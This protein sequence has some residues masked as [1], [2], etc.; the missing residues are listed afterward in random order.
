MGL[1]RG[2]TAESQVR[3][4]PDKVHK[5]TQRSPEHEPGAA[6]DSLY[7]NIDFGRG[8]FG[9]DAISEKTAKEKAE[10]TKALIYDQVC[11]FIK[12]Q[13]YERKPG[14]GS[15][16]SITEMWQSGEKKIRL[17]LSN[18]NLH[19]NI[20]YA[21][22]EEVSDILN[23][24]ALIKGKYEK[25]KFTPDRVKEKLTSDKVH[26][27]CVA[28]KFS[29]EALLADNI[30]ALKN[31]LKHKSA[32]VRRAA[33][34]ALGKIHSE[35]NQD[36]ILPMI[37][38]AD[39]HVSWVAAFEIAKYRNKKASTVM[40]E[41]L[42][43][44]KKPKIKGLPSERR[45]VLASAMLKIWPDKEMSKLLETG[46]ESQN[47]TVLSL[48][49]INSGRLQKYEDVTAFLEHKEPGIR[50]TAI[51][52]LCR[53]IDP[54]N[55]LEEVLE[56]TSHLTPYKEKLLSD[57]DLNIKRLAGKLF[58]AASREIEKVD[59][60]RMERVKEA[61]EAQ[62][63]GDAF[64]APVEFRTV[65]QIKEEYGDQEFETFKKNN[66]R[67]VVPGQP[68]DDTEEVMLLTRSMMISGG[69]E[70]NQFARLM[71]E[72]IFQ[73]D[74]GKIQNTGYGMNTIKSS[75][76]LYSGVNWRFID[77]NFKTNG[78]AMRMLP[79]AMQTSSIDQMVDDVI[80]CSKITHPHPEAYTGA[81][82]CALAFRLLLE[83]GSLSNE[84]LIDRLIAELSKVK[85]A[86]QKFIDALK[87]I[88]PLLPAL[89]TMSKDQITQMYGGNSSKAIESIPYAFAIFFKNRNEPIK[90]LNESVVI[91]GDSDSVGSIVATLLSLSGQKLP[92]Q[93]TENIYKKSVVDHYAR[94]ILTV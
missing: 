63:I 58:G 10:I 69:F 36:L 20:F 16:G 67:P 68:T 60:E 49:I 42:D 75:R 39:E 28:S 54:S 83:D 47:L 33:V 51:V 40:E 79:L 4:M 61:Y 94:G 46:L 86:E 29:G 91:D 1:D 30:P 81:L 37:Y 41:L 15:V 59:F 45:W 84:E 7:M 62:A 55:N 76:Y 32:L 93:L 9:E 87:K 80:T 77:N 5:I 66:N 43:F 90:A 57:P 2:K 24:L 65:E 88:K 50:E 14:M 27:L 70:P 92:K 13:G 64:G 21:Q 89:A 19:I 26:D 52:A 38:D 11:R 23:Q 22:P 18:G 78:A 8:V 17:V 31:L 73:M 25:D 74:L 85:D 53:V 48:A 71:G 72:H 82:Q 35:E 12:G 3:D 34:I 44:K 6:Y 56:P